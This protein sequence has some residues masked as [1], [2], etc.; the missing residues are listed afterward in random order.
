MMKLEKALICTAPL[1]LLARDACCSGVSQLVLIESPFL[2]LTDDDKYHTHTLSLSLFH[3]GAR[4]EQVR[5][6]NKRIPTKYIK[7]QQR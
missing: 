5:A 1:T 2:N 6:T 7:A 3:T 4:K